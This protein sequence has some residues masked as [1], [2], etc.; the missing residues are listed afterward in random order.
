MNSSKIIDPEEQR[1]KS[2]YPKFP[3][4]QVT[5]SLLKSPNVQGGFLDAVCSDLQ[6]NASNVLPEIITA[7]TQEEEQRVQR[8]LIATIAEAAPVEACD[9]LTGNLE[10][11]DESI[12]YWA[13]RGLEGIGTKDARAALYLWQSST[14]KERSS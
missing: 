2:R 8:I 7:F 13:A 14:N 1:Y 6:A 3:G 9:F 5:V 10:S 4:V 11:N 12:R